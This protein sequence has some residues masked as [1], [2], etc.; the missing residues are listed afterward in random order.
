MHYATVTKPEIGTKLR[1]AS[2][3]TKLTS[4][5]WQHQE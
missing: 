4:V 3:V 5:D 1:N 2:I